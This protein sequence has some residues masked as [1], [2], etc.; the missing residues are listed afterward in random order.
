MPPILDVVVR[1]P[2]FFSPFSPN[3]KLAYLNLC[4][5]LSWGGGGPRAKV[6]QP[7]GSIWPA[8]FFKQIKNVKNE[9]IITGF[10]LFNL[11]WG[12]NTLHPCSLKAAVS[13][14]II[15]ANFLSVC[16]LAISA[17][18]TTSPHECTAIARHGSK[19]KE[20]ALCVHEQTGLPLWWVL[21]RDWVLKWA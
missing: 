14:A 3:K 6:R 1:N 2:R 13:V 15:W 4:N 10:L 8:K 21:C 11:L 5:C 19:R 20:P 7:W 9:Y 17:P 16:D 18:L 12:K